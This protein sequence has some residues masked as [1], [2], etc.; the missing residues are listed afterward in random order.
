MV[1]DQQ[2]AGVGRWFEKFFRLPN[3]KTVIDSDSDSLMALSRFQNERVADDDW[4]FAELT[5]SIC[6]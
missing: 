6:R 1:P 2:T 5:P 3:P 4:T